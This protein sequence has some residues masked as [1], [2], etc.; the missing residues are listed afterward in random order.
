MRGMIENFLFKNESMD[1]NIESK[2]IEVLYLNSVSF[3]IAFTGAPVGQFKIQ[4]SDSGKKWATINPE[5]I[6]GEDGDL[7]ENQ[8]SGTPNEMMI[9]LRKG[10]IEGVRYVRFVYERTSGTG[11]LNVFFLARGA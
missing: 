5:N 1:A 4:I 7:S 11:E 10:D 2:P 8:P 3:E 6:A 9:I